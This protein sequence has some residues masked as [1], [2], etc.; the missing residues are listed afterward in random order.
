[1]YKNRT[2]LKESKTRLPIFSDLARLKF[3]QPIRY[4]PFETVMM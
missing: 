3:R 4:F 2:P 1:M